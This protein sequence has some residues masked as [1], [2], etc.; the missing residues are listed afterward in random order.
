MTRACSPKPLPAADARDGGVLRAGVDVHRDAA[1]RQLAR[2]V[3]H[4]DVHAA[5]FLA[6]QR[7]QRAGMDADHRNTFYHRQPRRQ[8]VTSAEL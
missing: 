1:P 6:A 5:R 2:Q 7:G 3:A 8:R 4:V